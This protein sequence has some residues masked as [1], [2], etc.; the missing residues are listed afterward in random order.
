MNVPQ[1]AFKIGNIGIYSYSVCIVLGIILGVILAGISK[2]KFEIKFDDLLEIFIYSL[3]G[4][5]LGARLYYCLFHIKFYLSNPSKIFAFR[6][7]GLAIY[8]GIIFGIL[9]AFLSSKIKKIDFR[10]LMD[11]IAPYLALAQG[12]GRVGNFFNVEAYG[13]ETAS[14]LR[15]GIFKNGNFIEVHP[16]FLY[17]GIACIIIFAILKVLQR[18]RKFKFE[19]F[20]KYM[21]FYGI[22]RFF[23]ERLRI[24]SLYLGG[25]KIS[26][27]VSIIFVIIGVIVHINESQKKSNFVNRNMG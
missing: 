9:I 1:I 12:I 10:D 26:Q 2:E 8:G 27:A 17:E 19:I 23:I 21:I 16:C 18:K 15:M 7:G 20:S 3:M 14:F 22:V 24:D 11:Y 25:I 13:Y 4:G 5:I 6:D